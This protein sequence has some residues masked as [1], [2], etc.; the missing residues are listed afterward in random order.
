MQEE[1]RITVGAEG[2]RS[3]VA[4]MVGAPE[5]NEQPAT[6]SRT[7]H[8]GATCPCKQRSCTRARIAC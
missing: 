6:T 2:V 7:T 3:V 8:I 4:R 5:Y 1:A